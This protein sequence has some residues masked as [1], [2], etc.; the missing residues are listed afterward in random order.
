MKEQNK[1][2]FLKSEKKDINNFTEIST[3]DWYQKNII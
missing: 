2:V 1:T 3:F